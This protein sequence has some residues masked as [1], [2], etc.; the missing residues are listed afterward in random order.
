M[1][2]YSIYKI[3][4]KE[5]GK[6]YIGATQD[7]VQRFRYYRKYKF[8]KTVFNYEILY[9]SKDKTHVF[10]TMEPH[11]IKEYNSL[12]PKGYNIQK[13]GRNGRCDKA[14]VLSENE[15]EGLSSIFDVNLLIR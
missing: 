5:N 14:L 6:I 3:T 4:H 8:D 2:I 10:N 12:T 13:G 9:Q 7:Y 1:L 11:F 15:L